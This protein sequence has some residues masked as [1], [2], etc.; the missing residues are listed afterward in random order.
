MQRRNLAILAAA[1]TIAATL[2]A[3]LGALPAQAQTFITFGGGSTGGAF[4]I[5]SAGMAR[6]VEKNVPNVRATARVT[7]ATLENTRLLGQ[8]RIEF[9]LAA[10]DGPYNAANAK[11][12]FANERYDNIRYVAT[13]YSSPFQIMVQGG[14]TIRSVSDL[15]GRRV[16]VLVG[17]TAQ[18]WFPRVAETYGINGRFQQ[19]LLRAAELMNSLRD[20]NI[21]AAVY[22]GA[23]P[24]PAITDLATSRPLRFIPIDRER[25]DQVIQTHPFF[26][27]DAIPA[28]TY[29]GQAEGVNSLFNPILLVVRADVPDDLVYAVTK[30]LLDTHHDELR[31][32]HPAAG[33]FRTQNGGRSMVVPVH[34][35][36][37]RFYAEKGVRLP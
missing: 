35:G 9:A 8:R 29:P 6:V 33:Q 2:G 28:N 3:T 24:T 19:F 27:F 36:A 30:A 22:S 20:G 26:F 12:A 16:G 23:A 31:A 25:A 4:H 32:I 34:P 10:S 5:I 14:S 17:V 7:A 15:A 11:G 37:A 18:D 21:D 13:G 1:T